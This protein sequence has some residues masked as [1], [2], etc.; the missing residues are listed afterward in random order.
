MMRFFFLPALLISHFIGYAQ[1]TCPYDLNFDGF[2]T[3]GELLVFA[4]NYGS[5]NNTDYDFNENGIRDIEDAL[6]FSRYLGI[7]CP[8]AEVQEASGNIIGLYVE[9]VDTLEAAL[10]DMD[11]IPAGSI[12]YRL[13]AEV[14]N[15]DVA[16]TGVGVRKNIL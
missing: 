15:P 14:S 8:Q 11:L 13:Y 4:A 5:P 6:I 1:N 10:A 16:V 12:T 9:P 7:Q 2:T 3:Y